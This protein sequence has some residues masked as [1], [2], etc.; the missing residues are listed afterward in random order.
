MT[1]K[2]F[3]QTKIEVIKGLKAQKREYIQQSQAINEQIRGFDI[4]KNNLTKDL[5]KDF[6]KPEDIRS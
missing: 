2:E 6:K 5:Q 4:E 3:L 1:K